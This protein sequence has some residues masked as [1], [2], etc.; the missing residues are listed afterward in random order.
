MSE[1]K[2]N[3]WIAHLTGPVGALF[4]CIF[5]I[6]YLGNFIDKMSD[7]HFKA[8]DRFVIENEEARKEQT[9]QMIILSNSISKL[10]EEVQK[11]KE[12]CKEEQQ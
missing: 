8:I 7:R 1:K 5:G 9:Q 6:Y 11:L 2:E 3:H 10:S 4:I 12:C